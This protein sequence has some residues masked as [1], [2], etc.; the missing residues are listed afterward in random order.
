VGRLLDIKAIMHLKYTLDPEIGNS[1]EFYI[2]KEKVQANLV[3]EFSS[4]SRF[5]RILSIYDYDGV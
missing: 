1:I 2:T 5:S 3:K 4:I